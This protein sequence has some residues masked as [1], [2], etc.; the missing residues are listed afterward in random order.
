MLVDGV[1]DDIDGFGVPV[2]DRLTRI[3][4]LQEGAPLLVLRTVNGD[5]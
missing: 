4:A 2:G 3:A 1:V 5:Q